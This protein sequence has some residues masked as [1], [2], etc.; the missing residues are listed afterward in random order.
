M[1]A[2]EQFEKAMMSMSEQLDELR[3]QYVSRWQAR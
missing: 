1:S 3:K 2:H